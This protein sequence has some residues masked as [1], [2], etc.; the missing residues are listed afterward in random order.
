MLPHENFELIILTGL[1]GAGKSQTVRFF[2]DAGFFCM[3][4][5]PP[6]LLP[7]FVQLCRESQGNISKAALVIDIRGGAFFNN[8]SQNLDALNEM[9]VSYRILFLEASDEVLVRRFSETRRKHP[10][11]L[12]GRVIEDIQ[13][14]RKLLAELREKADVIINTSELSIKDLYEEIR[15]F[16]EHSVAIRQMSLVFISF[17]FKFGLP[18]DCDM[19][20]DLRF[21]PN[22]YY[23]ADMKC[24]SGLDKRVSDYVIGSEIGS[25]FALRLK[26]MVEF[27]I[28]QF[29]M[30]PKSRVHIGIGCTG[31]RHRSVAFAEYLFNEVQHDKVLLSRRHRDLELS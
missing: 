30:E 9:K 11:G 1:S 27:L 21:L 24:L 19:L 16:I 12:G 20:F 25:E 8:F 26:N 28:P 17:G 13:Y 18:L 10:V 2:E 31:G 6:A 29:L 15:K 4:N 7:K 5:L 22:P 3:D 23:I 14:E